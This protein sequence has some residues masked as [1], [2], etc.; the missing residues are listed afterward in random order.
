MSSLFWTL[1]KPDELWMDVRMSRTVVLRII[2][3]GIKIVRRDSV[4]SV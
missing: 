2:G 3:S 4:S 1:W